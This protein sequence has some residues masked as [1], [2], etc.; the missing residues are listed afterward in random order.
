MLFLY[1]YNYSGVLALIVANVL[2]PDDTVLSEVQRASYIVAANLLLFYSFTS[3]VIQAH[4]TLQQ[5]QMYKSVASG[6]P[7]RDDASED[8]KS[9]RGYS[10]TLAGALRS[11]FFFFVC[12]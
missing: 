3:P 10:T 4:H 12:C 5:M 11:R 6:P 1:M 2:P 8:S 9:A 7:S